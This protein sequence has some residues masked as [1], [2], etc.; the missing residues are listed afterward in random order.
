MINSYQPI[1]LIG[2]ARS[3]TKLVRDLIAVHP[4]VDRVS[5]DINYVW[6]LGNEDL[7]HD[8][9]PVERLTSDIRQRIRQKFDC[10]HTGRPFVVEKT[11]S[12][13]LRVPFVAAVFPTAKFI[14]LVRDGVDVI[15]SVYRQWQAP[16]D[17]GYIIQKART[18]PVTEAWGYA[19][20]YARNTV[21]KLAKPNNHSSTWGPRYPGIDQD[22]ASRYLLEVCATQWNR[23]VVQAT[24][25]LAQLPANQ[26]LTLQYEA[27]VQHPLE[28]LEKIARFVGL[29]MAGPY[30]Q[31]VRETI[32]SLENIGKGR[33]RLSAE[34][35]A[36]VAPY[37][38]VPWPSKPAGR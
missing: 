14:H 28:H 5:Y 1:I 20:T 21:A 27:F 10:F 6:R 22:V 32:I 30:Q 25:D 24:S 23:C 3:G 19:L 8:A 35:L 26:V 38:Q 18:F 37:M 11:V 33:R 17:W 34:Q 4:Q 29:E 12:N 7:P 13:C 2:A 16:P 36:L 15:E 9:L 31:A